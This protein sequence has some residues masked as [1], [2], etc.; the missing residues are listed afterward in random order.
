MRVPTPL[1]FAVPPLG[2]C[3]SFFGQYVLMWSPCPLCI[4]QR[5]ALLAI[6]LALNLYK[7]IP[8]TVAATVTLLS[9]TGG[10]VAAYQ[11]YMLTQPPSLECGG[12]AGY[13]LWILSADYPILEGLLRA[14]G[15][16]QDSSYA[17][18]GIPLPVASLVLFCFIASIAFGKLAEL[19]RK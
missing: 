19:M 16:C 10:A 14:D 4:L 6:V 3:G 1:L 2:L 7:A 13:Y 11:A 18:M 15:N 9:L 17:I 5:L 8:K 12:A